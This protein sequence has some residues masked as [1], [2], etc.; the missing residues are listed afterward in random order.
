MQRVEVKNEYLTKGTSI[1]ESGQKGYVFQF[2]KEGS[3]FR[4][5]QIISCREHLLAF[6]RSAGGTQPCHE[7]AGVCPW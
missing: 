3:G 4:I 2:A 6:G 5:P 7:P 1:E